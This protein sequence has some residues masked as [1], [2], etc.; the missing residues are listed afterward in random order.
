MLGERTG[1]HRHRPRADP[2]HLKVRLE[3]DKVFA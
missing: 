1:R 3:Q 2:Y